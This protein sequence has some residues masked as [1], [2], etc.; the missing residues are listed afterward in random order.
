MKVTGEM[1]KNA[2]EKI[3]IMESEYSDSFVRN[4]QRL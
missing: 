1:R 4:T 3:R 2:K